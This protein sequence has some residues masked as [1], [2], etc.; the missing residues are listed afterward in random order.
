MRI[1]KLI[2]S[3]IVVCLI[4]MSVATAC[5]KE[6]EICTITFVQNGQKDIIKT[7]EKGADLTDIPAPAPVVDAEVVWDITDFTN[8]QNSLTVT[9]I[10]TPIY[11]ITFVQDGQENI[12]KTAKK[13]T[14]LT[15]IPTPAPVVGHD[16]S[17]SVTDFS[18]IQSDITVTVNETPKT[19]TITY[20]LNGVAQQNGVVLS[21]NPQTVTYGQAFTLLEKPTYTVDGVEYV[22]TAWLYNGQEFTDG[23]WEFTQDITLTMSYFEPVEIPEW[24]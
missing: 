7:I 14:A 19:Y 1:L 2:T 6:P 10:V 13:G 11:K 17:W 16:V 3:L 20:V 5:T 23:T 12:I 15:D 24:M 9:A 21:D 18:N 22:L 4:P 8:I